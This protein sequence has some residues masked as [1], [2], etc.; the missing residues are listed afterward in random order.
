MYTVACHAGFLRTYVLEMDP[1]QYQLDVN[2]A[3][4]GEAPDVY[5]TFNVL[6]RRDAK[7]NNFKVRR[8]FTSP[9]CCFPLKGHMA[10]G[11]CTK[12]PSHWPQL[13]RGEFRTGFARILYSHCATSELQKH[14]HIVCDA[15]PKASACISPSLPVPL[16]P[17]CWQFCN[18]RCVAGLCRLCW[19]PSVTA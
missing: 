18:H 9:N 8:R 12:G 15:A 7:E 3:A 1:A 5:S 4:A 11:C 2:A 16:L 13:E 17:A 19:S 6:M 14:T 10:L